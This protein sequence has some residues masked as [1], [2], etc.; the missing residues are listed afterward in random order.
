[1][2]RLGFLAAFLFLLWLQTLFTQ[3]AHIVDGQL[4]IFRY[5]WIAWLFLG[6][7]VLTL[8]G[9]AEIARRVLKDRFITMTC[10]GGVLLFAFLSLQLVYERVELTEEVLKHRREPPHTEFNADIPWSSIASVTKVRREIGGFFAPNFYNVGY[11][12]SLTDGTTVQLPS[13]TV[14]TSAQGVIDTRLESRNLPI[15]VR[16]VPIPK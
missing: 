5:N 9:F 15:A 12:F 11:E 10:W 4:H 13:N 16:D 7:M 2:F 1:M 8:I 3:T 14:L 6:L